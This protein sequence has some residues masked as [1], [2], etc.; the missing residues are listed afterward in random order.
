M[1]TAQLQAAIAAEDPQQ[2]Q[3]VLERAAAARFAA[4]GADADALYQ[5][6][7]QL[8]SV[9]DARAEAAAAE[10]A[11]AAAAAADAEANEN[12]NANENE[13]AKENTNAGGD[14]SGNASGKDERS[15]LEK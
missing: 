2:L 10:A 15:N 13:N 12:A 8:K 3:V 14:D 11:A 6:A 4:E 7:L 9:I 5:E 1:V